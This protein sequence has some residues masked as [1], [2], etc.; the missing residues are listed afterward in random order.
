MDGATYGL[1]NAGSKTD[2]YAWGTTNYGYN[3]IY[4]LL[5]AT[6]G[7]SAPETYTYAGDAYDG[8][9]QPDIHHHVLLGFRLIVVDIC[10]GGNTITHHVRRL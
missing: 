1:N 3:N 5:S 8:F 6:Q 4:E 7:A 10:Q 9:E 2:L